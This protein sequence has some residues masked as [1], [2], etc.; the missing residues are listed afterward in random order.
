MAFEMLKI[1]SN[2]Y[3]GPENN[4]KNFILKI[5]YIWFIYIY[6]LIHF[7]LMKKK[8]II[9][10]YRYYINSK[11]K[12]YKLWKIKLRINRGPVI[13]GVIGFHKP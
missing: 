1:A 11:I 7:L 8:K 2:T 9:L 10:L 6:F 5:G 13:A 3:Y 4:K 12:F